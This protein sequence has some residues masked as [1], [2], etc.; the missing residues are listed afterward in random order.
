MQ[1]KKKEQQL[2]ANPPKTVEQQNFESQWKAGDPQNEDKK[3]DVPMPSTSKPLMPPPPSDPREF[4]DDCYD[5]IEQFG[6]PEPIVESFNSERVWP[7]ICVNSNIPCLDFAV[8]EPKP[9]PES[10]IPIIDLDPEENVAEPEE[11]PPLATFRA[12]KRQVIGIKDLIEE[13]GRSKRPEK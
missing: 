7:A 10:D 1:K 6:S 13:P 5:G 9:K 4:T 8:E 2:V 12:F 3:V 11:P